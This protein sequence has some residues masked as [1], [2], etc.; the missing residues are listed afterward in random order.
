[1]LGSHDKVDIQLQAYNLAFEELGLNWHLLRAYD[2]DFLV[3]AIEQAKS[4]CERRQ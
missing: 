2:A 1:M 4:R 3:A